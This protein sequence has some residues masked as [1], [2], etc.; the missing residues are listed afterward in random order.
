MKGL[1]VNDLLKFNFV[2]EPVQAPDGTSVIYV[3]RSINKKKKYQSQLYKIDL[4]TGKEQVFTQDK[5][6]VASPTFSPDG[7]KIAFIS[8]RSG[9]KQVWLIDTHGGE[10]S[11]LTDFPHGASDPVW[12]PSGKQLIASTSLEIDE[13]LEQPKEGKNE[14]ELKAYATNRL[15]YK[16]DGQGLLTEKY[17]QLV[18]IHLSDQRTTVLT[19][20]T[21]NHGDVAFSPDEQ[22]IAF[23]ANREQDA[24]YRI[25]SDLYT[26]ELSTLVL[27]KQTNSDFSLSKP[28]FSP[29][30][31][32]ISLLGSNLAFKTASLARVMIVNRETTN[33]TILTKDFDVQASDVALN[34][35]GSDAGTAGAVWANDNQSLFFLASQNGATSLYQV[36]LE[37]VVTKLI[38]GNEQIYHFSLNKDQSQAVIAISDQLTPGDLYLTS[39]NGKEKNRLTNANEG[40]LNEVSIAQAEE[41][42]LTAY[43][44]T[45]LHGWIQKPMG[46]QEGEQYPLIVEIHGGPHMMYSFGFMHEF[47]ALANEGY[48]VLYIN[49][50]G[51]HGYGQ[52]FVNANRG[53]YGG[54]DYQDIMAAVDYVLD[55][56]DWIDQERLGVT[57]GSYGGFMTNW[58]VGHTNRF[59]AAVTQRSISNWQSFYG[60]S[61][62]GY[63]FTEYELKADFL[64]EPERLWDCSPIKYVNQIETPL[65]ILHSEEDHRCPIEQAEQLY[66]A[67]KMRKQPTRLVR[68]PKSS[69]GLSRNG[70]PSLRIERLTEIIDWF[71]KYL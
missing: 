1:S 71:E 34:D 56:F 12:S 70:D 25:T 39:L 41:I 57:G 5:G 42:Q 61:D 38:G 2:Q 22:V 13:T 51:S 58:I 24:D 43:D 48:G 60:V 44:G 6:T 49:P 7:K 69:H 11:Q 68:F 37:G 36:D 30:G 67:L 9:K 20:G 28:N 31:K 33:L 63:F 59:K 46:Y 66:V 23:V 26:L 15:A 4:V 29:D 50:R 40:L 16:A 10:A 21:Y 8:D 19:N 53:D 62:I 3:K 52:A 27:T 47:Q 17:H 64:S 45:A 18:L 32:L 14:G 54:G 65:L 35:M 55:N